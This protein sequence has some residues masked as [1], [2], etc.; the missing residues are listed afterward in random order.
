MRNQP[1]DSRP[2]RVFICELENRRTAHA[3]PINCRAG[4]EVFQVP[5]YTQ[6]PHSGNWGVSVGEGPQFPARL[7]REGPKHWTPG[8]PSPRT[9]SIRNVSPLLIFVN[10]TSD[11][12]SPHRRAPCCVIWHGGFE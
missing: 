10:G 7:K 2:E 1:V 12:E 9:A 6:S 3:R 4:S 5:R 11:L 8:Q